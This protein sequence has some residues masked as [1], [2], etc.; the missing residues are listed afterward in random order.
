MYTSAKLALMWGTLLSV[1]STGISGTGMATHAYKVIQPNPCSATLPANRDLPTTSGIQTSTTLKAGSYAFDLNQFGP[2]GLDKQVRRL[3]GV[4]LPMGDAVATWR[5][6]LPG[7]TRTYI[8]LAH[9]FKVGAQRIAQHA[10]LWGGVSYFI[11]GAG[12]SALRA[13]AVTVT[14]DALV[15][16][17]TGQPA[18]INLRVN[19]GHY[20][21]AGYIH[22]H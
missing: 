17:R 1:G 2:Q 20:T 10:C 4:T 6:R 11:Q 12:M 13:R 3:H 5:F 21:V 19:G 9:V 14:M 22:V 16:M 18:Q 15:G 7:G 8:G